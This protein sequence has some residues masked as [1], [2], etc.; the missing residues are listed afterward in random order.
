M[1]PQFKKHQLFSTWSPPGRL[2]PMSCAGSHHLHWWDAGALLP[3]RHWVWMITHVCDCWPW[4]GGCAY[5][6][7]ISPRVCGAQHQTLPFVPGQTSQQDLG[8]TVTCAK[9]KG[10]GSPRYPCNQGT[11][12][13]VVPSLRAKWA[14]TKAC[15]LRHLHHSWQPEKL[16]G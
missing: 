7:E 14:L 12:A 15:I 1:I 3:S 2:Q 8:R 13:V 10:K 5:V 4:K 11:E 6:P 9:W 16:L